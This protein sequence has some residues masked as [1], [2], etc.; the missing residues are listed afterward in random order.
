MNER[1]VEATLLCWKY[2][3]E[4]WRRTCPPMR[5][6]TVEPSSY[7]VVPL[8]HETADIANTSAAAGLVQYLCTTSA[9]ADMHALHSSSPGRTEA[10][11]KPARDSQFECCVVH[12]NVWVRLQHEETARSWTTAAA[13]HSG[14]GVVE[15]TE[16]CLSRCNAARAEQ[17]FLF[18]L[19]CR[20]YAAFPWD[21][22]C[23]WKRWSN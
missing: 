12:Q 8:Y 14:L 11:A 5:K 10:S 3:F 1:D 4:L 7:S 13:K 18:D 6:P 15:R 9:G 19:L 22:Q 16:K 20:C 2:L 23:C 17:S 21:C